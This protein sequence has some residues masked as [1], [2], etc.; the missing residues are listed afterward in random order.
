MM[1]KKMMMMMTTTTMMMVTMTT[2]KQMTTTMVGTTTMI[3]MTTMMM[4]LTMTTAT[5]MIAEVIHFN[6][7]EVRHGDTERHRYKLQSENCR[8][9]VKRLRKTTKTS[10]GTERKSV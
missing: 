5:A 8:T 6:P 9:V 2:M 3:M 4:K 10:L 1:I 7:G